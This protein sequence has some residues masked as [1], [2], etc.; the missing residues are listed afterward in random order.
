[1][2][3]A[4][5]F[6]VVIAYQYCTMIYKVTFCVS[7]CKR[8]NIFANEGHV[9][10]ATLHYEERAQRELEVGWVKLQRSHAII[11]KNLGFLREPSKD[12]KT[13]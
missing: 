6:A 3:V 7:L 11:A 4:P 1:M 8:Q 12:S 2:K 10:L 5:K 13:W 9:M